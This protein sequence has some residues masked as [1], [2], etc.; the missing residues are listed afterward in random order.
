VPGLASRPCFLWE[1]NN[2]GRRKHR[3]HKHRRRHPTEWPSQ[4][5]TRVHMSESSSRKIT[6]V[7]FQEAWVLLLSNCGD[8]DTGPDVASAHNR[9]IHKVGQANR[10]YVLSYSPPPTLRI[11]TSRLAGRENRV[12]SYQL[13]VITYRRSTPYVT[14]NMRLNEGTRPR[15]E[16]TKKRVTRTPEAHT[17]DHVVIVLRNRARW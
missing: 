15:V 11:H 7:G 8:V 2:G 9:K 1:I 13:H 5:R 12:C 4:T 10:R 16:I 14:T 3:T 17:I 6:P